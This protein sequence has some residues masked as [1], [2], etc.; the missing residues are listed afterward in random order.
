MSARNPVP[1]T[2]DAMPV[3]LTATESE[4]QR[5]DRFQRDVIP[6]TSQIL[7]AAARLTCT[8]QDAEDLT[9]EVMLRAYAGFGTFRDGTS[10]KAWLHRIL[11]NTWIS[12]YRKKKCRPVEVSVDCL[13]DQQLAAVVLRTSSA[14]RSAEDC[15]L[16]SIH[17]DEVATALAAL[18]SDTRTTVFY[19]DVMDLSCR[20]I[21]IITNCPI[22]TVLSRLHRG[23]KRLR[24]SLFTSAARQD[25]TSEQQR[26]TTSHAA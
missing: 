16:E 6:L 2:T 8:R 15:A 20:E 10:A 3:P 26:V 14:M 12:Q 24:A 4:A 5:A 25:F 22:G 9:Q 13:T 7:A 23:R 21:A 17:D 19:A 1:T 18:Q 11:H